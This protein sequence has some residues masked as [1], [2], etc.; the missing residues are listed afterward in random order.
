MTTIK[1]IIESKKEEIKNL[2][3]GLI[4]EEPYEN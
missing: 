2:F 3:N 1:E 4:K